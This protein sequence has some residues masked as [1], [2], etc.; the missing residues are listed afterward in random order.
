MKLEIKL[1]SHDGSIPRSKVAAGQAFALA[2]TPDGNNGVLL[3]AI[4]NAQPNETHLV[5]PGGWCP[6]VDLHT[7]AL[8]WINGS[9]AV[10]L[11]DAAVVVQVKK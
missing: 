5:G 10:W 1:T 9:T 8:R 7:G 4:F 6:S 11:Q 2:P 3:M